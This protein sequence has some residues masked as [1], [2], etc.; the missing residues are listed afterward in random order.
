MAIGADADA[1]DARLQGS[2]LLGREAVTCDRARSVALGE[3][4]G[5]AQQRLRAFD[6]R[7]LVEV[8]PG[9]ALAV[10]GVHQQLG[11]I[12]Q[13][14]RRDVQYVGAVLGQD[15]AA[16]RPGQHARQVEHA[17]AGERS[18]A[19]WQ[20][21]RRRI[22]DLHDVDQRQARDCLAVRMGVPFV[23]AAGHAADAAALVDRLLDVEGVPFGDGG[24]QRWLS[25]R[26]F[27]S[28]DPGRARGSAP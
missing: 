22:A 4:V 25:G 13:M 1:D 18:V 7:R 28:S 2:D 6:V 10:A 20:R 9:T 27:R 3:D 11:L 16:G 21:S 14:R 23:A 5:V 15:A 19:L 26:R 17:H 8:E 24:G 12:G